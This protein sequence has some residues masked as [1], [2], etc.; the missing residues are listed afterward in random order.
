MHVNNMSHFGKIVFIVG[1]VFIFLGA[2]VMLFDRFGIHP[3]KLPGDIIYRK[4]NTTIY[5]PIAT[6]ILLSILL[7]LFFWI[8]RK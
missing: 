3:G 5:I 2:A 7:S 4:G 6:S 8:F 1:I